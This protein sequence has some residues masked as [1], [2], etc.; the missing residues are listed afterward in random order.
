[1]AAEVSAQLQVS[2]PAASRPDHGS[3]RIG[4]L[5]AV[6]GEAGTRFQLERAEVVR[7]LFDE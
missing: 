4:T 3:L 1:V 7:R 2:A 6:L 5:A